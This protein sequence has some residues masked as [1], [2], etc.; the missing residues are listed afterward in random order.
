MA[1]KVKS[2]WE[3]SKRQRLQP[4]TKLAELAKQANKCRDQSKSVRQTRVCWRPRQTL[5]NTQPQIHSHTNTRGIA[6]KGPGSHVIKRP[7]LF[8][9][10]KWKMSW[11]ITWQPRSPR[12]YCLLTL[13]SANVCLQTYLSLSPCMCVYVCVSVAFDV[14]SLQRAL[15]GIQTRLTHYPQSRNYSYLSLWRQ[16]LKASHTQSRV[17]VRL[18]V[19]ESVCTCEYVCK[20]LMCLPC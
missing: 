9:W 20:Y 14:I 3:E 13:Q 7:L 10:Q 6:D 4:N 18:C 1:S 15:S 2:K 19:C 8:R 17:C 12:V 5:A 11:W 16:Q